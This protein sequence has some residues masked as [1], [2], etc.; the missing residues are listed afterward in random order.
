MMPIQTYKPTE[1]FVLGKLRKFEFLE[2]RPKRPLNLEALPKADFA[3]PCLRD[4]F[5]QLVEALD[6]F[7]VRREIVVSD[8][9]TYYKSATSVTFTKKSC[10]TNIHE[11]CKK[12]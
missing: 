9:P 8:L 1:E 10:F 6:D 7:V 3:V 5:K 2:A 4:F 12:E 11:N